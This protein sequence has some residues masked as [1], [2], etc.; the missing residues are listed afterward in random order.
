[1]TAEVNQQSYY[2]RTSLVDSCGNEVLT[3][4]PMR[5]ILLEGEKIDAQKISLGWNAF[6]GW[7][8]GVGEYKVYRALN[9]TGSF[10]AIGTT[11]AGN[12]T[13][14]DDIAML[15]GQTNQVRY[16]I[17]AFRNQHPN[18]TSL[19]NE[20]LF[21]FAPSLFLPNA[22]TP[23][24]RNP[25]FKPVGT[26]AQFTEYRMDIYNRWGELVFTSQDFGEGWDGSYKGDIA[27]S[28]AYV[29]VLFYRSSA[30]QEE[31]LKQSFVLIR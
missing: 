8:E 6:E 30:G 13:F 1:M 7:P 10:Q 22:F 29:C 15:S 2:Y 9:A 11:Q 5:T 20:V 28:G 26:F 12:L 4:A 25:V 24:G 3:T 19:S 17:G 23:G 31:T 21:E 27:P 18:F 14:E 16:I